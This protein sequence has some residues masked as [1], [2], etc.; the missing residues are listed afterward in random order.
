MTDSLTRFR[1]NSWPQERAL[2]TES[3]EALYSGHLGSSKSRTMCEKGNAYA[4]LWKQSR[5]AAC[6]KKRVDL[7]IST[8]RM[9]REKVVPPGFWSA[10]YRPGAE[11]ASTLFYPNG[12]E[13]HFIGL[14]NPMK[15]LSTEYDLILIDQAEEI[16]L[17]EWRNA[18]GR[19]RHVAGPF[20]QIMGFVNPADPAHW[21]YDYFQPD[22]GSHC[23]FSTEAFT[24]PD[25]RVV[26]PGQ[27]LREC[28]RAGLADN[29]ENLDAK[30]LQVIHSYRGRWY[31]RYV[32]GRWVAFE[33]VIYDCWEPDVHLVSRPAAWAKWGGYPPPDWPIYRA[34]DFGFTNPFVCQWWAVDPDD[35]WW[36]YQELYGTRQTILTWAE[37]VLALDKKQLDTVREREKVNARD[38]RRDAHDIEFL[39]IYL[40]VADHD[41]G[42]RAI[43]EEQYGIPTE[44]ADKRDVSVG[45]QTVYQMMVPFLSDPLDPKS[46][47]VSRL[48]FLR[49][50]LAPE[51]VDEA[52]VYAG[53]PSCTLAE[54]PRYRIQEYRSSVTG[55][56]PREEP[57]KKDDHGCDAMRMLLHTVRSLGDMRAV[58]V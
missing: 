20:Q 45:L 6:R 57:F 33:G 47:R 8:L 3:R 19:L 54:I 46:R 1:P 53:R 23:Q 26:P 14:D 15:L 56:G 9:W 32:L 52:L 55:E 48:H 51:N 37:R 50:A 34:F 43:L 42:E 4:R 24:T 44:P 30:Y 21:M 35:H 27:L 5:I 18:A 12:S 36:L 16:E 10:R 17:E 28:I 13:V 38:E 29:M 41:A 7:G 25:G 58:R 31:E 2:V 49:D 22:L 11:G 39:P 40:N